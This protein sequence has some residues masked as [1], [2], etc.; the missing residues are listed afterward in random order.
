[1]KIHIENRT[2]LPLKIVGEVIDRWQ[3]YI[4]G[5]TCYIGKLWTLDFECGNKQFI[6]EILI[7]KSCVSVFVIEK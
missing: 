6:M 3:D 1:M 5:E 4:G 2:D 7:G